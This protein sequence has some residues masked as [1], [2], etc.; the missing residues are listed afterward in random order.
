MKIMVTGGMGFIG[1]HLV[2]MLLEKYNTQIVVLDALTYAA[3]TPLYTKKQASRVRLIKADIR[4]HLVVSRVMAEVKPDVIF[5]LAAESH[6]C[7]SIQGPKDFMLTNINGT[8]NLIEEFKNLWKANN[9]GKA[10][11]HISTDEVFG[12]L[13][14][15]DEPF[16]EETCLRPRSPYASSKAASDHIV[17]SYFET[18]KVNTKIVNCSNNYGVNQHEEKL[19]PKSICAILRKEPVE[20]YGNGEQVRDWLYVTD[21]CQAIIK[22]FERGRVGERYCIGGDSE[23]SNITV[24][25]HIHKAVQD[26]FP[27]EKIPLLLKYNKVA[28]PT[29][30][31]RYAI[32]NQKMRDLGWK[33]LPNLLQQRLRSI[34]LWYYGKIQSGEVAGAR[35][36]KE[37]S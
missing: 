11:I 34:V 20:V 6:V 26:L 30:D 28:R 29:D 5:H 18:Y 2:K 33:P 17:Q 31:R 32:Y 1:S 12:Q 8:W 10:F 25:S 15:K 27:E 36:A 23:L 13:G 24:I 21:C 7:K 35:P 37:G 4:D 14:A 22:V 3:R 16:N 9:H 19:I